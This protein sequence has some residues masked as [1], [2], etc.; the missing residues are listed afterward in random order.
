MR[1]SHYGD[2]DP[3]CQGDSDSANEEELFETAKHMGMAPDDMRDREFAEKYA[4]WLRGQ[5]D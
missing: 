3:Q 1:M 5:E 2:E 4:A